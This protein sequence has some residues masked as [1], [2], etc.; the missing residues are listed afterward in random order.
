MKK[1]T[2]VLTFSA[3]LASLSTAHGQN[4]SH[5]F[6]VRATS[7]SGFPTGEAFLTGGGTYDAQSGFL[8]ARGAFRCTQGIAQG[9]LA[10]CNAGDG[11]R[12]EGANILPSITFKC[13]GSA[14]EA[15]KTAVTD[16]STLAM[17]AEFYRRGDGVIASFR[18]NMIVSATDLDPDQPGVQNVWIQGVGCGTADVNL[19]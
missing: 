14:A 16:G 2:A 3:L 6:S 8:Q 5:S 19:R 12:W 1:L 18:A 11:V 17:Q 7:I 10:G 13:T 4:S 15:A 9:P